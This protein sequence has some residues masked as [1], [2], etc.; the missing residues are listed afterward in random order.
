VVNRT[1]MR[2]HLREDMVARIVERTQS[3]R[4]LELHEVAEAIE[5]LL[6]PDASSS[7]APEPTYLGGL[8]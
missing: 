7:P 4:C 5:A 1:G 3:K 2:E 6:A 8:P